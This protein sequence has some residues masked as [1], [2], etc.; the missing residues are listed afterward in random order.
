[1]VWCACGPNGREC[2]KVAA[3][4]SSRG[5][6]RWGGGE[7]EEGDG[8]EKKEKKDWR[9]PFLETTGIIEGLEAG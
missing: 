8:G 4:R 5:K 2:L 6:V 7:G 9:V 3:T 1:M